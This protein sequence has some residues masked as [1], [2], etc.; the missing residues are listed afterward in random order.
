MQEKWTFKT[1]LF[2]IIA[3]L[4]CPKYYSSQYLYNNDECLDVLA[5]PGISSKFS[6]SETNLL[7][8]DYDKI[9]DMSKRM[10]IISTVSTATV[11]STSSFYLGDESSVQVHP[12]FCHPVWQHKYQCMG[13]VTVVGCDY[14]PNYIPKW[15]LVLC[16]VLDNFAMTWPHQAWSV[17]CCVDK[18]LIYTWIYFIIKFKNLIRNGTYPNPSNS[19]HTFRSAKCAYKG[20]QVLKPIDYSAWD[21]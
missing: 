19:P 21:I 9:P 15:N 13:L 8:L 1:E 16:Q 17:P 6:Q 5:L 12:H 7:A 20:R 4:W 3:G 10:S 18:Y 2:E 11:D 14:N